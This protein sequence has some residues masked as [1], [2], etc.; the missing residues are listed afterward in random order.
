MSNRLRAIGI[1]IATTLVVGV[2]GGYWYTLG[3]PGTPHTGPLPP[4]S[5]EQKDLAGVLR[6]HVVAIATKPRNTD[7]PEA[8]EAAARYLD[9]TLASFGFKVIPQRFRADRIEVRN[10]EVVI[11]PSGARTQ[12]LVVGAHYDSAFDAPGANDN[13]SGTAALLEIA[14]RLKA[15][16]PV[17]TRLRLVFFVNEEPPHFQEPT[18]G[19]L[20]YAKALAATGERVR[21]MIS[22]ET[23]GH[24]SDEPGS[25][26]YPPPFASVLPNKGNFVGLVGALSARPFVADVVGAFRDLVPF[27]SV[28]GVA[29]ADIPGIMWSDHWSFAEVGIP[30]IMITDTALFRYRHYHKPTDTPD[31]LDYEKLARVTLGLTAVIRRLSP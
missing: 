19:S 24:Y 29:P 3:L 27:P 17:T 7:H 9:A 22:L 1:V 18:M 2:L 25:Q 30:G 28:A 4:L 23:L 16:P 12:T 6:R 11:E 15:T 26:K 31:K 20:V 5:A 21:G 14:R 13:G 10:L 8:L